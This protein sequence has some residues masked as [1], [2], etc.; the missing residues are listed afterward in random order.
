MLNRYR[1]KNE[2]Q[3]LS[4]GS[5]F[6]LF[7]LIIANIRAVLGQSI[8]IKNITDDFDRF[9]RL[10]YDAKSSEVKQVSLTSNEKNFI[11]EALLSSCNEVGL[12]RLIT[13][14]NFK[15]VI[16]PKKY[17]QAPLGSNVQTYA[18][19][20]DKYKEII[21]H[22]F[23]LDDLNDVSRKKQLIAI[24]NN[25]LSTVLS[26]HTKRN[27]L[28]KNNQSASGLFKMAPWTSD[29]EFKKISNAFKQYQTRVEEYRNLSEKSKSKLSTEE[30]KKLKKYDRAI[31]TYDIF[32]Y[33]KYKNTVFDIQ[34]KKT[35]ALKKSNRNGFFADYDHRDSVLSSE[36]Y[37]QRKHTNLAE[38]IS[39]FDM[40][41]EKIKKTFGKEL[42]EGLDKLHELPPGMYCSRV[43]T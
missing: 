3:S 34:S 6:T 1:L 30:Q 8:P 22:K 18:S 4:W 15:I 19:Y 16:A 32:L 36:A 39:D 9:Y 40:L 33:G 24:L 21:I 25:E 2:T 43:K 29:N 28:A 7:I 17:L 14:D 12:R 11:R 42:C 23:V 5:L 20:N 35:K 37:S 38:R 41:P 31:E 26:R 10:T 27:K 13:D